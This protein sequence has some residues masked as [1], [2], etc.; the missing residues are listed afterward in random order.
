MPI[1]VNLSAGYSF[2]L[3]RKLRNDL[4]IHTFQK[5]RNYETF[6]IRNDFLIYELCLKDCM[7]F[8]PTEFGLD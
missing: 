7:E 4:T 3:L 5:R 8:Y 2:L 6:R 1:V